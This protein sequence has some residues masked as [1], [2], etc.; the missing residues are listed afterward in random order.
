MCVIVKYT[1]QQNLKEIKIF[2]N[3]RKCLNEQ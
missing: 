1:Q 3:T 2:K